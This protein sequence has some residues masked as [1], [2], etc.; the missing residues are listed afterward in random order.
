M[1]NST[2]SNVKIMQMYQESGCD[3]N[4]DE[5]EEP[6]RNVCA[7]SSIEYVLLICAQWS[8]DLVV[9]SPLYPFL[10]HWVLSTL[11]CCILPMLLLPFTILQESTYCP[12]FVS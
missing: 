5:A 8:S 6:F 1:R 3:W 4:S 2:A 10:I 11:F 9:C 12:F 7:R